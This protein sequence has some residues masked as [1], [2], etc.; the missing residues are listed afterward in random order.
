MAKGRA[1]RGGQYE[2]LILTL[3]ASDISLDDKNKKQMVSEDNFEEKRVKL[4]KAY[5]PIATVI[6]LTRVIK[7]FSPTTCFPFLIT[8]KGV[9]T[10]QLAYKNANNLNLTKATV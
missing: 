5:A 2:Y 8:K 4:H 7:V 6:L 9:E 1:S 3:F 10:H